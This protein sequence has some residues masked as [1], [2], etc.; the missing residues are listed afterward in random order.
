MVIFSFIGSQNVTF[1]NLELCQC[2][3]LYSFL[4][5]QNESNK[6]IMF[7]KI[8][9]VCNMSVKRDSTIEEQSPK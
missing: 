1:V 3:Y 4:A 7:N 8:K 6:T 9:P 5:T 2:Y